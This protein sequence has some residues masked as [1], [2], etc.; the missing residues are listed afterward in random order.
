M[1]LVEVNA[2]APCPQNEISS[3]LLNLWT[4]LHTASVYLIFLLIKFNIK[5]IPRS[6]QV[7]IGSVMQAHTVP[8]TLRIKRFTSTS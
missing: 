6:K 5:L 3:E 8:A 2:W 1:V 7:S 4:K